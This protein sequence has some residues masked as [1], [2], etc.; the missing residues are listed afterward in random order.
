MVIKYHELGESA[1]TRGERGLEGGGREGGE[2][3]GE[4]HS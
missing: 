1:V 3:D 4:T 2:G